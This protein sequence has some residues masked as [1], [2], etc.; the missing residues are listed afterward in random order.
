MFPRQQLLSAVIAASTLVAGA[1]A[2]ACSCG[3]KVAAHGNAY[4]RQSLVADF[5]T[6][7]L[8]GTAT[9]AS[10]LNDYGFHIADGYKGG[11][12]SSAPDH[13]DPIAHFEN[14]RVQNGALELVVPGGQKITN[15]GKTTGAQIEGPS[16]M[17][18]GVF[19]MTAKIEKTP[20]TDQ[21]MVRARGDVYGGE[22]TCVQFTYHGQATGTQDEQDM[23]ILGSYLYQKG[24]NGTPAGIELTVSGRKHATECP[25]LT[26][27][28]HR[29]GTRRTPR[30]RGATT[31]SSRSRP[32][33]RPHSTTIRAL[34]AVSGVR[35]RADASQNRV[36]V[37]QDDLLHGHDR[38][39][40]PA[41]VP[42][43]EPV[44]ARDQPL[45]KRRP[46][47]QLH[48]SLRGGRLTTIQPSSLRA[49]PP[50]TPSCR[51]SQAHSLIPRSADVMLAVKQIIAYYSLAGQTDPPSGCNQADFC[52]V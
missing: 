12:T 46:C 52:V 40:Q 5:T 2:A 39:G 17:I 26:G 4:F 45:D 10:W 34:A 33:L 18:G 30:T 50:R 35:G 47:V 25:R 1:H 51:V 13:T 3:Y 8:S 24:D 14:V 27:S 23:E 16:N 42:F 28:R 7:K 22:L 20:G 49:R 15:G 48:R 38:A 19:T 44:G 31:R 6:A 32:T 11:G 9:S 29:T 37:G 36:A 43:D 21:S 41:P